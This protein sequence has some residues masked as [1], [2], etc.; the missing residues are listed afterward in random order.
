MNRLESEL[1][2]LY[3]LQ[4]PA[5]Q[6]AEAEEPRLIDADGRVRAMVLELARPADW[7]VLSKVWHGVQVDL[8]LPAPAIAVSGTDGYQLWF[9]LAQPLPAAQ[10]WAFMEALRQRYLGDIRTHRVGLLPTVDAASP[11]QAVHAR[12]VPALQADSGHW[13]AFVA[14]DLAP[15]FAEE[16][17]LDLPP[18]LDGQAAL[19]TGLASIPLAELERALALLQPAA[20]PAL[21]APAP[22]SA[23]VADAGL[24][25]MNLRSHSPGPWLDPKRF[26]LDVMNNDA[27]ALALRIEA[28]KALLPCFDDPRRETG[29]R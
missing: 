17:W 13:S 8:D 2:R 10:A 19:L 1:Q 27:V 12:R 15:V 9:S 7:A 23:A 22:P 28:A 21:S 6:H 26:L 24:G 5:S 20:T 11:P 29:A 25:T 3:L 4:V 14:P 18:N 16:P